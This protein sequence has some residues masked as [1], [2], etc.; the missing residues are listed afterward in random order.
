MRE[1]GKIEVSLMTTSVSHVHAIIYGDTNGFLRFSLLG[2]FFKSIF[3]RSPGFLH[4]A[5]TLKMLCISVVNSGLTS[6]KQGCIMNISLYFYEI[7]SSLRNT[8]AY[9]WSYV[10]VSVFLG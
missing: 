4:I 2:F 8:M 9:Y 5:V 6:K 1:F 7:F 10:K 3:K